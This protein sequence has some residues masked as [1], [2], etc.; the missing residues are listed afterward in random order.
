[1]SM[2]RLAWS[3]QSWVPQPAFRRAI[4]PQKPRRDEGREFW[5]GAA[6]HWTALLLPDGTVFAELINF[7]MLGKP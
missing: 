7:R 5:L 2:A 1:M 3:R 4:I 6:P